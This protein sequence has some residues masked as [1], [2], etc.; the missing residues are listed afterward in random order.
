MGRSPGTRA[1]A[2]LIPLAACKLIDQTTFTRV[3]PGPGPAELAAMPVGR[4]ALLTIR[5]AT[6]A[7]DYTAPLTAAVDAAGRQRPGVGFDV[8][9][10]IPVEHDP[11]L[12]AQRL[13]RAQ[14]NVAEVMQR[15]VL[16][17]VPEQ[18]IR[19]GAETDPQITVQE[20]RV[21]IR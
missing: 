15:M 8:V 16:L 11:V 5:Y 18:R 14:R 12:E 9:A 3:P 7:P 1:L 17:G 13:A 19:L 4:S 10:A 6:P 2:L 20:V 21:Y